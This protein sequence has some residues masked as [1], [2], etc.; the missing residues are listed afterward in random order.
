VSQ[1][2]H[3]P[4]R[5]HFFCGKAGAGKSTLARAIA[6]AEGATLICED[7]WLSRL[8]GDQMQTFDDYRR[9]AQR[10]KT[11]VGPLCLDLLRAGGTVV[12]DFPAN[13]R[14]ARDWFRALGEQAG[15]E[16]VLHDVASTDA[17]CLARI[18]RRNA[19]RPEGSH[20]LTPELFAQIS[21]FFELPAQD[22]G[23][24]VQRH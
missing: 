18:E 12:M 14:A 2:P 6:E 5:L 24:Q 22:E 19:E 20:H 7:V 9:L 23:F 21:A 4:G 1:S 3:A 17:T 11:V 15:A 10:L 13:T 16:A 8:Y